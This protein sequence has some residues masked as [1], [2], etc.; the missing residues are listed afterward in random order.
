MVKKKEDI[1]NSSGFLHLV[2]YIFLTL[3]SNAILRLLRM[4]C[5]TLKYGP[6]HLILFASPINLIT[7]L[8]WITRLRERVGNFK[9]LSLSE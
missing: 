3:S 7:L 9:M 2:Q 8:I 6:V 5:L 1:F 4:V